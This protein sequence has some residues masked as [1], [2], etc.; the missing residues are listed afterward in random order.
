MNLF[1]E[2]SG[3]FQIFQRKWSCREDCVCVCVMWVYGDIYVAGQIVSRDAVRMRQTRRGWC[4]D[5]G[6]TQPHSDVLKMRRDKTGTFWDA[7]WNSGNDEAPV[8][9]FFSIQTTH[10]GKSEG[11]TYS[12]IISPMTCVTSISMGTLGTPNMIMDNRLDYNIL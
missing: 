2:R 9:G 10:Q 11:V 6:E 8:L 3:W 1:W 7:I 4:R 12:V 5:G